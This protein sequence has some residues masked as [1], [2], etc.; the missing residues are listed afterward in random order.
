MQV[1][2]TRV[3]GL[4]REYHVVF[5]AAELDKRAAER[6]SALKDRVQLAGF[7]PGKVPLPYLKRLY[8]KSVMGEVIEQAISE[9][10]GKIVNDGGFR[11]A[12]EP[13]VT[14][15]NQEEAAVKEMVEGRADLAYT[16]AFEVLP[17]I[18]LTD[19]KAISLVRPVHEP[20]P[21]EVDETVKNIADANRPFA[22][23]PAGAKAERGDRIVVSFTGTIEGKP[24]E[25]GS[26]EEVPVVIGQGGFLPG[27]EEKLI[28]M[29]V[30]DNRTVD[31]TFPKN[32]LAE[33]L[34]GKDAVFQVTATRLEAPNEVTIDD[35][36]AKTLGLDS[37]AKL[38][39]Q[40]RERLSRSNA[41]VSRAKLKRRLLDALD[42]THKFDV[43]PSLVEQEFN[44]IWESVAREL[45]QSGKTFADQD[46]TEEAAREE[47]R[48]IADRRVRLGLVIAEIGE[49]NQIKVTDEEL[50]RA[51]I[52]RAR[53]FP[54][55]E[56]QVL[57]QYQRNPEALAGLRAPIFEDKVVDFI[58]ELVKVSDKPVTRDALYADD[59]EDSEATQKTAK[60]KSKDKAK[61]KGRKK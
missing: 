48:R 47:Y 6:L 39:E 44:G 20:T 27:F 35:A 34:A 16:V 46:T 33:Q 21:E 54:G 5:P 49:R 28:G 14:L 32:Y 52:E 41:Q 23:K 29:G 61:D 22:A 43:P 4:Q 50:R 59:D 53:Q 15:A 42:E 12:L 18:A 40:V 3:E 8:G 58:L 1:T 31:L 2:E 11:L 30:G 26:A 36:F 7:R 60:G 24:F 57:E 45:E 37:L 56:R 9:A 19:F 51:I 38:K 25:G 55:Q 10:N 17:K 13:R